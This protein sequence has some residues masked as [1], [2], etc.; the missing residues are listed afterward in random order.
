MKGKYMKQGTVGA[1]ALI[2]AISML[3]CGKTA[4]EIAST[5]AG[6]TTSGEHET[7]AVTMGRQTL[8]NV[9]FPNG[10]TY[11]D[12]A[13]IR[14]AN[15]ELNIKIEDAFEANG[16]DYDRQVSLALS[17]GDMP[18]I[19]K[20]NTLDEVKEL[21]DNGLIAD[22]TDVYKI[23]ASDNLKSIYD[24]YDGR[25]LENVTYDD[26]IVAI[27]GT[28]GDSGPS[29]VWVRSDW[30]KELGITLD[31]DENG[32][33]TVEELQNLAKEFMDKNPE[34]A[35]NPV[36]MAVTQYFTSAD[37]D[38]T[39][40]LNSLAYACNAFPKTW[41]KKDGKLTY[42]STTDEMK[43]TLEIAAQ[44]Y[45]DGI[46]DPQ[47]GTRTWDDIT[48]LL[49]NGQTGIAF[50]TWHIPDWL[51]NNVYAMNPK[52]TFDTYTLENSDGQVN[53]KHNDATSGYMVVS[54]SFKHPEVVVQLANL[55]YDKLGN[56]SSLL[57]KYPDVA[58][59][60]EDGIDGSTRPMNIEI[61]ASTSL[62]DDYQNVE[63]CL[64]GKITID[65]LK[66][67]D[68]KSNVTAIQGYTDGSSDATGWSKYH[69]RIK[70]VGLLKKLEDAG[71][72]QW[73]TPEFPGTT[74]TQ[75]TNQANLDKLEEETFIKIVTGELDVDKGFDQFVSDWK[76]QGGT[77]ITKEIE[78]Q[79]KK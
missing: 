17:S 51:L 33:I 34:N 36:G 67:I 26:K 24:S 59:Y 65:Q 9:T 69:S 12:N 56:D 4:T 76:S 77:Q 53:C 6:T 49:A 60:I 1:L 62:F 79:L 21:Y 52:A 68:Q 8:Q 45:K 39:Y 3:G 40:T 7:I 31:A 25:A 18:D 11:E 22:L 61:N 15:K 10:D 41:Y 47:V 48:A 20:V 57:E 58:Q 70:G 64:N 37:P 78:S 23:D 72:I 19:M 5:E 2:M 27:P 13:Y 29:I 30:A 54:K 16:D 74:E 28:N 73:L 50:G 32:C 75:K 66:K 38:G 44:W 42:G 55:F 71:K 35:E 14:M 63:D 43:K 46:L